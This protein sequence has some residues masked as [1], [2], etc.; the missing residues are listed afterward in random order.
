ML[1]T[2]PAKGGVKHVTG[3]RV[4]QCLNAPAR[5]F[6]IAPFINHFPGLQS[7]VQWRSVSSHGVTSCDIMAGTS[8]SPSRR[9]RTGTTRSSGAA[10]IARRIPSISAAQNAQLGIAVAARLAHIFSRVGP[11]SLAAAS[12]GAGSRLL[13]HGSNYRSPSHVVKYHRGL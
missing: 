4:L 6:I 5:I 10:G 3:Q 8:R 12:R 9:R 2:L 11:C 1:H 7:A 13:R